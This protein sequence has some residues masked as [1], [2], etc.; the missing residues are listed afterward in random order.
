[1]S[2]SVTTSKHRNDNQLIDLAL[3]T[4]THWPMSAVSSRKQLIF[5]CGPKVKR[6]GRQKNIFFAGVFCKAKLIFTV[7]TTWSNFKHYQ[8][9][10]FPAV[11]TFSVQL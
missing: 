11:E 2:H 9:L 3:E 10:T 5:I 6:H 7:P 1:L 4:E 8:A